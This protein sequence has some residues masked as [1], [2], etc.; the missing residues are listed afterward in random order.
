MPPRRP[1]CKCGG[2]KIFVKEQ[3]QGVLVRCPK[4]GKESVNY[5][6]SAYRWLTA[7]R[8]ADSPVKEG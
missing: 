4:C 8:A 2:I 3:G 7:K 5:S 6:K 1:Y